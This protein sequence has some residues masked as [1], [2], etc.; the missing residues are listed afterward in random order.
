MKIGVFDSG[1]GGLSV[2]HAIENAFPLATIVFV[3]DPEH[4]PY[5][6][7]SP[8]EIW[9]GIVPI[10]QDLIDQKCDVIVVAC[11]TVSTTLI[12]RLRETFPAMTFVGLEPMVK[13][14]VQLS[15]NKAIC[16]CATPTT[17]AS[18]RYKEL[19]QQYAADV[20]VIEPDCTEWSRLIEENAINE[21]KLRAAIQPALASGA[22]VIVLGC[23]HYHW[24][25]QEIRN[26]VGDKAEILQPE[27]A[28]ISQ[29]TRL[30]SSASEPAA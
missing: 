6:T 13:P 20:L 1:I 11:N 26:I 2:A 15:A 22:D 5:A 30:L 19:K 10:F 28:V 17:L 25:E 29:L 27:Q 9:Q 8:D 14:A 23:T 18:P 24:I 3:T 12:Q 4:F 21:A 16:V 7:K